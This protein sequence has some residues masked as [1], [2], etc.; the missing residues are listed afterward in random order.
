MRRLTIP[1]DQGT[2]VYLLALETSGRRGAA[3]LFRGDPLD[4]SSLA[5][6]E[7]E[8]RLADHQR[9]AQSL[10]PAVAQ[11]LKACEVATAE[12][13]AIA[14]A[15]GPGS[16]TGL[17]IGVTAAKTLAYA[18][19]AVVVAVPT[20]TALAA[21]VPASPGRLWTI[22]DAQR[23][24]LY[25]TCYPALPRNRLA[26]ERALAQYPSAERPA[27][28]PARDA[29]SEQEFGRVSILAIDAW[30]G[31]LRAGDR[32][33]GPPL[34]QLVQRLP[35][36]VAAAHLD[37]NEPWARGVG[38]LGWRM[39]VGKQGIDPM[40]LVPAYSRASAAEEKSQGSGSGDQGAMGPTSAR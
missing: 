14:V 33:A 27:T 5:R 18:V 19:G 22:L 11:G 17:R 23:G 2:L 34:Q 7:W 9:T 8:V 32:V 21:S 15:S 40:Q 20:L 13:G 38:R 25:V 35:D 1:P 10:V 36:G 6:L 29:W 30:L 28:D 39:F 16:F 37:P 3:A 12:L 31:R 26:A 24:E 4:P